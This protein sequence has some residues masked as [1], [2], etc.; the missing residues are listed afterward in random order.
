MVA[1]HD[2]ELVVSALP[3]SLTHRQ[4]KQVIHH[5][6]HGLRYTSQHIFAVSQ[7]AQVQVSIGSEGDCYDNA[8]AESFFA[9]LDMELIDQQ[10]RRCFHN[11]AQAQTKSFDYVEGFYNPRCRHPDLSNQTNFLGCPLTCDNFIN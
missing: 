8:V 1:R 11:R 4:P 5:S 9:T 7:R 6:D 10:P 2:S 3:M